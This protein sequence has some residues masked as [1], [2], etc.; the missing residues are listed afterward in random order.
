MV[1]CLY[2]WIYTHFGARAWHW[3][4][5]SRHHHHQSYDHRSYT[6]SQFRHIALKCNINV[7]DATRLPTGFSHHSLHVSSYQDLLTWVEWRG[8]IYSKCRISEKKSRV[9]R[10]FE[11]KLIFCSVCCASLSKASLQ[12]SHFCRPVRGKETLVHLETFTKKS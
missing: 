10:T 6:T 8:N 2:F 7:C 1:V 3:G 12:M 5:H 9:K 4:Y 11:V